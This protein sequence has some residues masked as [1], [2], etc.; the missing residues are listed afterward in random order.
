MPDISREESKLRLLSCSQFVSSLASKDPVPGGGGAAALWGALGAALGNMVIQLTLGKRR[1]ADYEA[2]HLRIQEELTRLQEELLLMIDRDAEEFAPLAAA[3]GIKAETT[4]E[5]AAKEAILQSALQNACR[6]P[7]LIMQ[8]AYRC[9]QLQQ[10]L[11]PISSTIAISDIACGVQGLRAALLAAR[12][13]VLINLA[14]IEDAG[15]YE[16]L[17]LEINELTAK[18]VALADQ[19]FAAIEADFLE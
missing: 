1:Y 5:K 19:L 2:D 13:N 10:E 14:S 17:L 8:T 4:D 15:F 11:A 3:Y 18:G 6:I 12:V 9:L 16:G 7:L